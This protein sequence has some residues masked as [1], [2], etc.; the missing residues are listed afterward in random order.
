MSAGKPAESDETPLP[1]AEAV[2]AFLRANPDFLDRQ[3]ELLT[4]LTPPSRRQ[5]DGVIDMQ[6]FMVERQRAELVKIESAT[7]ELIEVGRNNLSVQTQVHAAVLSM[8]AATTFEHL[9]EIVTDQLAVTL[10]ADVVT[11]S[12]E[13]DENTLPRAVKAGVHVLSAGH[14][15]MALGT[16]DVRLLDD[17]EQADPIVFGPGSGLVRSAA[18]VRLVVSGAAPQGLLSI[19]ARRVDYFHP[20]Q[21]T[22]L[23]SF[24]ARVVEHCMRQ[25]LDLPRP[26]AGS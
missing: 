8:L 16:A 17:I 7:R 4:V 9:I 21:G 2:M 26:P 5:G 1:E 15:D 11:L 22:E 24:L 18:L 3:P 23:L 13:G 19:G 25:W 14:I 10:G 6:R 20:Q 12:F